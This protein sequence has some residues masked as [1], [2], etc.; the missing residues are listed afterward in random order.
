[1]TSWQLSE[2]VGA[3]PSSPFSAVFLNYVLPSASVV[4][5]LAK[6]AARIVCADGGANRLRDS[7][8]DIVPDAIVGDLD[9]IREDVAA[10]YREKRVSIIEDG[11]QYSTDMDK[12]VRW[13]IKQDPNDDIVIVASMGGRLDHSL[14]NI[15]SAFTAKANVK[16]FFVN[17]DCLGC[18]L[19]PVR[20]LFS[21]TSC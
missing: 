21:F 4:S 15:N 7:G 3:E 1:M 17:S 8:L 2:L 14:S 13:A 6:H 12:A 16:F 9:S 20:A 18:L 10:Y 19:L 11:D 5:H